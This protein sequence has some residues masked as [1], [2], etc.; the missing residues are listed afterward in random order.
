MTK[1]NVD[2]T[3]R[4]IIVE[5]NKEGYITASVKQIMQSRHEIIVSKRGIQKIIKKY[6]T[7]GLY[8]Y[9]KRSGRPVKLSERFRR[10]IRR[11]SLRNR[12][13]SVRSITS[14]FNIQRTEHIS[15]VR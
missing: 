6:D 9:K 5:L 4:A 1:R 7:T 14:N 11:M 2:L 8:E 13:M 12:T 15:R 3:N 10:I